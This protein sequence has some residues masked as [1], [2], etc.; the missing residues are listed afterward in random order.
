MQLGDSLGEIQVLE[1]MDEIASYAGNNWDRSR[2]S[3][4]L[5]PHLGLMTYDVM[6]CLA[7]RKTKRSTGT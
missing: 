7:R 4:K 1:L 2:V 6:L 5:K 3:L